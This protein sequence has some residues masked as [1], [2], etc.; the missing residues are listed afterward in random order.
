ML[1]RIPRIIWLVCAVL[2]VV[3]VLRLP[4]GYYSFLRIV[5]CGAA[6]LIA[7]AGLAE[8]THVGIDVTSLI[9]MRRNRTAGRR[10]LGRFR[11]REVLGSDKQVDR[12]RPRYFSQ[13]P[14][15]HLY[16]RGPDRNDG[17]RWGRHTF[18]GAL[19]GTG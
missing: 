18:P 8:E 19:R 14:A 13:R 4:Y 1:Q 17:E 3:A 16:P 6:A 5:I 2:L 7:V 9:D 12:R 15:R 11:Y 10:R